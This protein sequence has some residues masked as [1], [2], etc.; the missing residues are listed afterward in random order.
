VDSAHCLVVGGDQSRVV[1]WV[2]AEDR[3]PPLVERFI[4]L[5][6]TRNIVVKVQSD[7]EQ[8]FKTSPQ[9]DPQQLRSTDNLV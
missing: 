6:A 8:L 1:Y 7:V 4:L 9:Q 2:P 3:W 5:V